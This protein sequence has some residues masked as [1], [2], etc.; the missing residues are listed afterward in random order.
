MVDKRDHPNMNQYFSAAPPEDEI[1]PGFTPPCRGVSMR[2]A[3]LKQKAAA[4][5]VFKRKR[6]RQEAEPFS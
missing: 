1:H 6:L 2:R 3:M 4:R 5:Y